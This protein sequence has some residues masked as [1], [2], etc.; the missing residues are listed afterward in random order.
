MPGGASPTVYLYR[1]LA[2]VWSADA[3]IS[4]PQ[5]G[6]EFGAAVHLDPT[7]LFV[8]SPGASANRGGRVRLW[9]RPPS[10]ECD[11]E[12]D[13]GAPKAPTADGGQSGDRF[14]ASLDSS[15]DYLVVGAAH[16]A[17]DT[18]AVTDTVAHASSGFPHRRIGRRLAWLIPRVRSAKICSAH[19]SPSTSTHIDRRSAPGRIPTSSGSKTYSQGEAF[20]YGLKSN[21]QWTLETPADQPE[22]H[23]LT[24]AA[25]PRATTSVTRSPSAAI[26]P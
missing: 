26:S 21:G 4:S 1:K 19:R 22:I 8:G 14:G 6:I 18:G 5:T 10:S 12:C 20:S 24:G 3:T 23:V 7:S 16:A 2:G 17:S 15:G 9:P 13:A 11:L 25:L